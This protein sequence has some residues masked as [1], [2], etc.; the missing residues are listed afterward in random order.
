MWNLMEVSIPSFLEELVLVNVPKLEK[1]VGTYGLDLTSNLRVLMVKDCP[2][3]SEF[4]LFDSNY[5]HVE[6]KSCFLSL[7]E[8]TIGH[9]HH[10]IVWKI[11]LLEEMR[12]LKELELIDVPVIEELS[13]PSLEKLVLIQLPSL[14]I[15]NGITAKLRKLTIHDCPSLTVPLPLILSC[16]RISDLSIKGLSAFPTMEIITG[17]VFNIT[18]KELIELDVRIV[19]FHNLKTIRNLHLNCC[20][21]LTCI[22]S[23]G[24]SQLIA[25]KFLDIRCCPNLVQPYVM[26][27]HVDESSRH[28]L[29]LPSLRCI[30][31]RSCGIAGRWLTQMLTHLQSLESLYL[32][33]CPQ[34]RF[35]SINQ[36]TQPETT[37]ARDEHLLNI[38]CNVIRSLKRLG[39]QECPDLEFSRVNGGFRGCTSLVMLQ[40]HGC[41][42]LVSSSVTETND[43]LL[44][45]T[46]LQDLWI[47]PLPENLQSYFHK[48][49]AC[50]KNL[51]SLQLHHPQL[52]V[53]EGVQH[54]SALRSLDIKMNNRKLQEQGQGSNHTLL[55]P[56]TLEELSIKY[57]QDSDVHSRLLC[58][59]SLTRLELGHSPDLKSL[60]LGYCTSLQVACFY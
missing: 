22:S 32:C 16:P 31:I 17:G 57:L 41:P 4:T 46:S 2:Q 43:N 28:N 10:I 18:S 59:P 8:L 29:V 56:L 45:P 48:G 55:F 51:K 52:G 60:Q 42:K 33:D 30:S 58:L 39:I 20:P 40:I 34:I 37:S 3:L 44:L 6:Q 5:F 38:P 15:C 11:L 23:E 7:E 47:S 25:L 36:P 27:E 50:L 19:P 54:L 21:K 26:S 12:A 1:C 9:C 35:L 14:Q 49:L 13:V 24:F 53:L